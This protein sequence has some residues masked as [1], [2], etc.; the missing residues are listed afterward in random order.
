MDSARYPGP[1]V[2]LYVSMRQI[3]HKD[4]EQLKSSA[5][6]YYNYWTERSLPSLRSFRRLDFFLLFYEERQL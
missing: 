2:T 1:G 5:E 4:I 3:E 6:P